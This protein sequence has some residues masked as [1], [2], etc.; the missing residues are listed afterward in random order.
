MLLHPQPEDHLPVP[1]H[2]LKL[3]E[4]DVELA[5]ALLRTPKIILALLEDS[6]IAAQRAV[7]KHHPSREQMVVKEN[8]HIR[9]QGLPPT[10]DPACSR[11]CP[12]ISAVGS[13]HIDQ[14]VQVRAA[15]AGQWAAEEGAGSARLADRRGAARSPP[16]LQVAG[17]VVRTGSIKMF[18]AQKMFECNRCKD[19]CAPGRRCRR[20]PLRARC[21]GSSAPGA[22]EA[23]AARGPAALQPWL[24][25]RPSPA[26]SC[27]A[28]AWRMAAP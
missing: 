5:D 16:A 3:A 2:G 27:S 18:E 1:L 6:L 26:G 20:A 28:A 9:L 23:A 19:R 15:K 22:L 14:L 4:A 12:G 17:T 21:A 8:A 11:F 13:R 25:A 10:T 24:R 7:M